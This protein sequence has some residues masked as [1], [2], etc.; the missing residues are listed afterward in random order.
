M[1]LSLKLFSNLMEYLPADAE[2]NTVKLDLPASTSCN[3]L[4][5]RY[6]IPHTA[7]Q[8]VMLNGDFLPAEQR[9]LPLQDGDGIAVWPSIQGG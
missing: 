1:K 8:V 5:N 3:D 7:V 2:D 6:R 4:I 9:D